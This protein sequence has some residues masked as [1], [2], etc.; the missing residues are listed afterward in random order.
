MTSPMTLDRITA[1]ALVDA[2]YTPLRD[3]IEQF[4]E[5]SQSDSQARRSPV[6]LDL[7]NHRTRPWGVPGPLNKR[8]R[9]RDGHSTGMKNSAA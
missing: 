4:G 8:P 3:Y 2:G 1:Q 9:R 7:G 5:T 6:V